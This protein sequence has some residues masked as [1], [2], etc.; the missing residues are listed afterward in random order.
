MLSVTVLRKL[1]FLLFVYIARGRSGQIFF[2]TFESLNYTIMSQFGR[3]EEFDCSSNDVDSYFERLHSFYRANGVRDDAKVDVFLSVVGCKTYKLLKSLLAPTLPSAKSID[4]LQQVLKKHVQPTDSVI[5]RRSKFYTRKQK[6]TESITDFVA[7]LKLLA[8]DCE[9]EAFLD[10]ALRDIFALGVADRETQRKLREVKQLTFAKAVDIALARESISRELSG[11]THSEASGVH[12]LAFPRAGRA[13]RESRQHRGGRGRGA[14]GRHSQSHGQQST[15]GTGAGNCYRCGQNHHASACRFKQ[16]ECHFCHKKGHLKSMCRNNVRFLDSQMSEEEEVQE[17]TLGIFHT[18]GCHSTK[19]KEPWKATLTVDK[20]PMSMEIDTGSGKSLIG[21]DIWQQHFPNK[22]LTKSPVTLTTYSGDRLPLMGSCMVQVQHQGQTEILE[23]LV[24]D[25]TDQPAII[26]RDWL[27]RV[28]IDWS[29][30]FHIKNTSLQQVLEEHKAVFGKGLGKMKDFK[31]KLHLKPEVKPKFIKA[32]SVP[33]ALRSK[34]EASLEELERDGVLE[35]VTHSDWGS[36]IVVVPKKTGDVRICGDYKATLNQALDVDQHPLPK[37]SD[38]FA[39]LAGGKVFSKLDLTQAYHQMEVEEG[40]QHLLT[41]TTH[42]GLYRY[43]RLPF[44]VNSAPA[45]FQRTMEQILQGIPGVAVFMDDIELTGSTTEEHLDRLNQVL[46]RL[47]EYGLRL[48]KSK[49][50]FLKDS[51]EYLG[52]IIDKDGLHPVPGK[53]K[54]ITEA[55]QPT[56]VSELRSYLGMLQYYAR[57]LP[58]LSSELSPLHE[59]LKD[60]APWHWTDSCQAAFL[61][62]KQLLTS[63]KVL[64]HYDVNLPIRLECDA[65][66]MGLG[67]VI[68]HEMPD[69]THRPVAYASR[70]LSK[71]ERNYAQIEKEALA[72]VFGV[73]KFHDY[74]YGRRFTLVT[75]HKPLL[76]I[77]G[78]KKGVPTLAAARMQRWALIL[79]AYQY[80]LHFRATDEHKNAD[81]LSRLPLEGEDLT[82]SEE[83]IFNITCTSD[84]PVSAHQ[85]AEATRKDPLMSR[86]LSHTRKGWPAHNSDRELQPYFSRR[87]EIS[88]EEGGLRVIIPPAFRNRMLEEL[89]EQHPGI[90]RMKALSRS[91]IWWPGIDADIEGK[92]KACH[93][94]KRV[95]NTPP[96]APL[97]P[98]SWPTR[99]WQ[100]LHVDY[101]EHQGQYFFVL[102]DAHSKWPEIFAMTKTTTEKTITI[103]RH[104]FSSYGLP[105]EIVSD[106]G[107][108]FTSDLFADFLQQNGIKHTRSAPY[109]PAT[110]GAAERMVQV[111]KKTL[112]RSSGLSMDHQLA[113]LLL[114]YR[115]TPHT[116]TGVPPAELFLKRQL[117]TRLTLLRPDQEATIR[118]KQRQQK[119]QH[120]HDSK[121]LRT[122]QPGDHVAVRQF[123][124]PE[125]WVPGIIVQSLGTV[126]Y[127]VNIN[128]RVTHVHVDHIVAAPPSAPL[129]DTQVTEAHP[130]SPDRPTDLTA[131]VRSPAHPPKPSLP[132]TLSPVPVTEGSTTAPVSSPSTSSTEGSTTSSVPSSLPKPVEP[133]GTR[134]SH[135]IRRKP[136]RMDL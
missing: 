62:T 74:L 86:V 99:P 133:V 84:L 78:P 79:A 7:E 104:L 69:G 47:E 109:H 103:L 21:K 132:E 8:A 9:F 121:Q 35:K 39:T 41:I 135:R 75:D 12:A 80:E 30:V 114:S 68:S 11:H 120:D 126:G 31:A 54:A 32:R 100:R 95:S 22:E 111:L 116:T 3:L 61:K 98:W 36:P 6:D 24:A 53:V 87:S 2:L 33:F 88:T 71:P 107:P 27:S 25:V 113:N 51:V 58:N 28:K 108:Q 70:T 42:K 76:A 29:K 56:N 18:S 122:F 125:K 124:G 40:H 92:V 85:I 23:L 46:Q 96:T 60:N 20:I 115:S 105:E 134:R 37:P 13:Q 119:E 1:S 128:N 52:H 72:L 106:N 90:F 17:E 127:M 93:D 10:Q 131:E 101:A 57:F 49:C 118:Q 73:K 129:Q 63:A 66:S 26:G 117:R 82:A 77:L 97:Q 64:T 91:Y 110:N 16:A 4:E 65:S 5:S 136:D 94:C 50:E 34:V 59:L 81:M 83:Q 14:S 48:K 45:I 44:G 102:T 38:L 15:A 55:P 43:R 130:Y 123:R 19:S 67:A 112:K 89:H